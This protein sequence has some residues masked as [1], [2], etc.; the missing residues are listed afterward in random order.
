M[1]KTGPPLKLWFYTISITVSIL[2]GFMAYSL[3]N[4]ERLGFKEVTNGLKEAIIKNNRESPMHTS[5]VL[6]GSSLT[7]CAFQNTSEIEK[8][9][10]K[11]NSRK[12]NVLRIAINGLN[13][14]IIDKIRFFDYITQSPPNYLFIESN[15]LNIDDNNPKDRFKILKLS[16]ENM[17]FLLKNI[18]GANNHYE[19]ITGKASIGSEFYKDNFDTTIYSKLL[20]KKRF[21]RTFL[22][23][24]TENK[25]FA[26]LIEK[27]TKIIFLDM[28]RAPKLESVYLDNK[29]KVELNNL[30]EYYQKNYNIECWKYPNVMSNS[31]FSDGGHLNYKG[32][33]KYSE[34][35]VTKFNS[36]K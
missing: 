8:K 36:L 27:N 14:K 12:R 31:D 16:L 17:T 19:M 9:T 33:K 13:N 15:H 30:L 3:S 24:K 5:I 32:A 34:W 29:Q 4:P 28:P 20:M 21:V 25:A 7:G 23:N 26:E 18:I 1:D 22:Q 35:F 2:L 6:L 10:S 11:N